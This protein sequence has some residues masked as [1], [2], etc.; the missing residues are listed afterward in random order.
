MNDFADYSLDIADYSTLVTL[1]GEITTFDEDTNTCTILTDDDLSFTA[2]LHPAVIEAYDKQ[3]YFL[4]VGDDVDML[5]PYINVDGKPKLLI[6]R[7]MIYPK[8]FGLVN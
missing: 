1:C 6:I 5:G 8:P 3:N 2:T 7:C 4:E